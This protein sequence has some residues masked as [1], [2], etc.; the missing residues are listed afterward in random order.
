MVLP[1]KRIVVKPPGRLLSMNGRVIRD[2]VPF[3]AHMILVPRV[4]VHHWGQRWQDRRHYV[5]QLHSSGACKSTLDEMGICVSR[6]N[7][8][9]PTSPPSSRSCPHPQ[10]TLQEACPAADSDLVVSG[11]QPRQ[12]ASDTAMHIARKLHAV[13]VHNSTGVKGVYNKDLN[14]YEMILVMWG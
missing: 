9:L 8:K 6:L 5:D 14:A 2:R 7:A 4:P 1:Y 10:T 12:S 13:I 11:P 3:L